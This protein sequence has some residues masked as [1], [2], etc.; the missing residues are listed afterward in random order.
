[1]ALYCFSLTLHLGVGSGGFSPTLEDLG[2]RFSEP[3]SSLQLF[4]KVEIS[5]CTLI[6]LFRPGSVHNGQCRNQ[7]RSELTGK[8]SGNIWPQSSQLAEPLWTDPGLKSG[9]SV[10]K[11]ISTLKKKK[12]R[13]GMNG[14]TIFPKFLQARNKAAATTTTIGTSRWEL[15]LPP[16]QKKFRPCKSCA[17]TLVYPRGVCLHIQSCQ[18]AEPLWMDPGLKLSLI[19]ISEPTRQNDI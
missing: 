7:S 4:F 1:M 18:F 16:Q 9:I 5:L 13:R 11:L 15:G 2:V 17:A 14:W 19:H 10:C 12:C 8:L 6:S 3:F